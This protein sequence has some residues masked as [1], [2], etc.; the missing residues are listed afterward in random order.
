MKR[1]AYLTIASLII[2]CGSPQQSTKKEQPEPSPAPKEKCTYSY[3]H[4]ST[5]IYWTA[6]KHTAKAPVQGQ[7]DSLEVTGANPSENATDVLDGLQF[8]IFTSSINSKDAARDKKIIESYFGAMESTD[9]ISGSVKS[10]VDG[11]AT[12]LLKINNIEK[13]Q[14]AEYKIEGEVLTLTAVV[15]IVNW[16]GQ[17]A[18]ESLNKVC[19]ERHTSTDGTSKL[20][21]DVKIL[22]ETTLNKECETL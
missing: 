7:F 18:V 8:K 15:D 12:L 1:I 3:N 2:S 5:G 14:T 21:P 4:S 16:E 19:Y 11:K 22:V 6:Y 9:V 10:A 17:G 20:W 13:E